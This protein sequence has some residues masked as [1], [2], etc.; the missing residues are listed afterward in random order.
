MDDVAEIQNVDSIIDRQDD[1]MIEFA[2][3]RGIACVLFFP[4]AA[5]QG[6]AGAPGQ[7]YHD[8]RG[9]GQARGHAGPGRAGV[10][11]GPL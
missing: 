7:P 1:E 2:R 10:A 11:A 3:E 4:P 8:R 6:R 5:V 9:R